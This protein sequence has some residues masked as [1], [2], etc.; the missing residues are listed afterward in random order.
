MTVYLDDHPCTVYC[1]VR[2][3]LPLLY[4][5]KNEVI[6]SEFRR[7][8][9]QAKI[10]ALLNGNRFIESMYTVLMKLTPP[11]TVWAKIGE[12]SGSY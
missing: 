11:T 2:T 4:S 8:T 3:V 5:I 12:R 1:T 6:T 7:F 9:Q 10:F